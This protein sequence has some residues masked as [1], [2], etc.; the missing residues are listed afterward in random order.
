MNYTTK[1]QIAPPKD[2]IKITNESLYETH[3]GM[4]LKMELK[5]QM[6]AKFGKLKN[7]S[8]GEIFSAL[9][10]AQ[11]RANK[12]TISAFEVRL[13]IQFRVPPYKAPEVHLEVHF[14]ICIKMD[15]KVHLRLH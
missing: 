11:E 6:N 2:L 14:K 1:S 12:T 9:G 15:K 7:E 13:M 3:L 8:N 5:V 10:D 4:L